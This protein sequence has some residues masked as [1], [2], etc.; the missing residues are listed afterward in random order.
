[1]NMFHSWEDEIAHENEICGS[2]FGPKI[3]SWYLSSKK[4][5]RWNDCGREALLVCAGLCKGAK[6]SIE[7]N[8]DRYG[9]PPDDLEYSCMKD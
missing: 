2:M 8:R 3:G 5:P 4:D 1:M 9:D 6:K 7:A